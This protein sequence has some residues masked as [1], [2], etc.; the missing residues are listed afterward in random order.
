MVTIEF[1]DYPGLAATQE[2]KVDVTTDEF[3]F[4]PD[5]LLKND[6]IPD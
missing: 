1:P 2:F 4:L 5:N 6:K 3:D